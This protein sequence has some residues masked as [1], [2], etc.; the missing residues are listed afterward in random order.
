[1]KKTW[2]H[3]NPF[4][5]NHVDIFAWS[6][7]IF[8]PS[9]VQISSHSL[10]KYHLTKFKISAVRHLGI[11]W[12]NLRRHF[13]GGYVMY[14]QELSYR[15]QIARQLRTQFVEGISVTWKSTSRV[16]QGHWK[17]NH[18]TDHTRLTVRRVIGRWILLWPWNVGQR[19]LKV[20]ESGTIWKFRYGFL[21]FPTLTITLTITVTLCLTPGLKVKVIENG[22][23]R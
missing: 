21:T 11:V 18:R 10:K 12:D 8:V 13:H 17:R 4:P 22:A 5:Q 16:T 14:K 6:C 15:K 19:S 1:M 3:I 20:I 9:S 7:C 2:R 23:V